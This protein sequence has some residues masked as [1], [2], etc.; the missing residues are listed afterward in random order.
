MTARCRCMKG[1][2]AACVRGCFVHMCSH[3]HGLDSAL[4][5]R[6]GNPSARHLCTKG[7]SISKEPA[8]SHPQPR[9]RASSVP[10]PGPLAGRAARLQR[11]AASHPLEPWWNLTLMNFRFSADLAGA[12]LVQTALVDLVYRVVSEALHNAKA[13]TRQ[14]VQR[15]APH[16]G[17]VGPKG[18]VDSAAFDAHQ[19]TQVDAAPVRP[20][21]IAV[22]TEPVAVHQGLHQ[23][24]VRGAGA[25]ESSIGLVIVAFLCGY[26]VGFHVFPGLRLQRERAI[27]GADDLE[28]VKIRVALYSLA[29]RAEHDVADL[30]RRP[31]F[32]LLVKEPS[33]HDLE[34][35]SL[36]VLADVAAA[37]PKIAL[38][39]YVGTRG[40]VD[41]GPLIDTVHY[42]RG[43]GND[44]VK[45][46]TASPPN[47]TLLILR[48]VLPTDA[49]H[50]FGGTAA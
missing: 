44:V 4:D 9:R 37:F 25:R 46:P 15:Q 19:D 23:L 30:C 14:D 1:S 47:R 10:L 43:C 2:I 32:K 49:V 18:T 27:S 13:L 24:K 36:P 42:C 16:F 20:W 39:D 5:T 41:L 29:N 50:I 8:C 28:A 38:F 3:S 17:D 31:P 35:A 48:H 40:R 26:R 6:K 34:V 7:E 21:P 33:G 11:S 22:H 12:N 45:V